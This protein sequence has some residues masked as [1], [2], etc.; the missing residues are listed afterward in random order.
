MKK[1]PLKR[2]SSTTGLSPG[3][4][5]HVGEIKTDHSTLSF[6][7][8]TADTCFQQDNAS[9][10]QCLEPRDS[11]ITTWINLDG[12]S[13]TDLIG[14]LGQHFGLHPLVQEDILN[15]GQRPKME[16]FD[17][18]IYVVLKM[19]FQPDNNDDIHEEQVSLIMGPDF[20]LSFQEQ[21]GDVFQPIRD[22]LL[23]GKGRIR[24]AGTDYLTYALIDVIVDN[25]F[26]ILEQL[27]ERIADM[28]DE[29][30][31]EPTPDTLETI[32]RLKHDLI[33]LRKSV[34]PLRELIS[35]LQRADSEMISN[36]TKIF[37]R[38]VYDHTI[39]VIDTIE[40]FR[41]MVSS[42]LDI[43][44]SSVSNRMNEIMKVLTLIATVFMPLTFIVGVYGMNFNYMP[45][46]HWK[47]GYPAVLGLMLS[48]GICMW[49]LFKRKKWL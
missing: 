41:D 11:A 46:L 16:D 18:Y 5:I 31:Q 26:I 48:I 23:A 34:W 32:H 38:D 21:P 42:M 1:K 33:H 35:G 45:E 6:M 17:N 2:T 20:V 25:Y 15:T 36:T 30:L 14:A 19:L 7:N 8:Y 39:Q 28:E 49:I 10:Q 4:L 44:L 47:W 43:Y 40:S 13:D 27:G 3:T 9:L 12:L 29:V 24:T 22:R 37:L